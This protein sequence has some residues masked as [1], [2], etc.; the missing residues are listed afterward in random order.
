MLE[1]VITR[2]GWAPS[3]LFPSIAVMNTLANLPLDATSLTMLAILKARPGARATLAAALS[4]LVPRTRAEPGCLDYTLFEYADE[5]GTYCM[6]ESFV[7]EVAFQAHLAAP[8]FQDFKA[9]LDEML[10]EPLRLV[11][12]TRLA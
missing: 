9:R 1:R 8:Y 2:D 4:A 5:P 10:D 3:A 7:D 12:L 6:R 11:R